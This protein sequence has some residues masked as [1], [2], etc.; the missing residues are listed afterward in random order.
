[1]IDRVELSPSRRGRSGRFLAGPARSAL[2]PPWPATAAATSR[3]IPAG[4]SSSS[5]TRRSIRCSSPPSSARR[6]RLRSSLRRCSGRAPRAGSVKE[7]VQAL[8]SAISEKADGIAVSI[9]DES[10]DSLRRRTAAARAGI[11]LVAFNVDS[12]SS[13]RRYAYVGENPRASGVNVGGEIARLAPPST[14]LL[15]APEQAKTWTERASRGCSPGSRHRR[16]RR[17]AT[18]VRLSGDAAKQQSAVEKAY[19]RRTRDPRALRGRRPRD[20]SRA[21]GRSSISA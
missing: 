16:R 17:A 18:V 13:G 9:L 19:A 15:F 11:P 20:R 5:A 4:G 2:P 6:T 21:A 1:M 8:R 14:V 7:T 3:H 12:G 10:R